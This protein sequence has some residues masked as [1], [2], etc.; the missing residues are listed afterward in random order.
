MRR[1]RRGR[2]ERLGLHIALLAVPIGIASCAT[3][4]PRDAPCVFPGPPRSAVA[5]RMSVSADSGFRGTV[6]HIDASPIAGVLVLVDPGDHKTMTDS[7]GQFR[8][9]DIP[10]GRYLLRAQLIG[11][12]EASDSVTYPEHGVEVLAALAPYEPGLLGCVRPA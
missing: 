10:R 9:E 2:A 5:S 12:V 4:L 8:F 11:L 6:V 3:P 1:I 7:L